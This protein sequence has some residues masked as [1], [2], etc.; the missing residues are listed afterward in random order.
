MLPILIVNTHKRSVSNYCS[1]VLLECH[2]SRTARDFR[3]VSADLRTIGWA[4]NGNVCL[5][6]CEPRELFARS[7]EAF[8]KLSRE[9]Q[10]RLDGGNEFFGGK[11]FPKYRMI[12]HKPDVLRQ[13]IAR[14]DA[15]RRVRH[16][17]RFGTGPKILY[18]E[19]D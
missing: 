3:R 19:L 1:L 5:W 14:H 12:A 15:R 6:C 17:S 4:S 7:R 11:W 16:D 18:E 9:Y 13:K 2:G 10:G 8:C